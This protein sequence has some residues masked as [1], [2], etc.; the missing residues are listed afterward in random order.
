MDAS[1]PNWGRPWR[2]LPL[3]LE[4]PIWALPRVVGGG[5]RV[6]SLAFFRYPF[7]EYHSYDEVITLMMKLP[8]LIS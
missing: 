7:V 5:F 8:M 2:R 1:M 4:A 6:A 3:A